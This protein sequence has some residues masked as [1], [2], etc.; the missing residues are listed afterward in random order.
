MGVLPSLKIR[1]NQR[2]HAKPPRIRNG[3]FFVCF[4]NPCASAP[5][6]E[7]VRSVLAHLRDGAQ[8]VRA[9]VP[10]PGFEVI[11]NLPKERRLEQKFVDLRF[12]ELAPMALRAFH[13]HPSSLFHRFLLARSSR[14]VGKHRRVA[15]E[16]GRAMNTTPT[17]AEG[18][19]GP[20]RRAF[21][22]FSSCPP[23]LQPPRR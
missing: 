16:S 21:F 12:H 20:P 18:R 10:E 13:A 1:R 19:K 14:H 15:P 9:P 23:R 17:K 3:D 11:L 7:V 6:R 2:P 22:S 5:P 8:V 4:A